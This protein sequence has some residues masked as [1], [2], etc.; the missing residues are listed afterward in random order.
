MPRNSSDFWL[1]VGFSQWEPPMQNWEETE[2]SKL[3]S[4]ATFPVR[5]P[6]VSCQAGWLALYQEPQSLSAP[7]FPTFG[8]CF[9]PLFLQVFSWKR[10][11]IIISSWLCNFTLTQ[12]SFFSNNLL[13]A[14]L[15][16]QFEY[17]VFYSCKSPD[18]H[19]A[20]MSWSGVVS[21]MVKRSW[22]WNVFG[23]WSQWY[24]MMDRL[25][26]MEER[27]EKKMILNI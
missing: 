2:V 4:F 18:W 16:H 22:I 20:F 3:N 15:I 12:I 5:L 6:R 25:W 8:T 11:P 23:K 27:N 26:E 17:T 14:L 10:F 1:L 21:V 9:L 19:G 24:L 13:N 7:H